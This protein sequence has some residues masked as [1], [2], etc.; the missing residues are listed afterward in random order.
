MEKL[1]REIL[2]L[3]IKRQRG[4]SERSLEVVKGD[5]ATANRSP[6][7]N[8]VIDPETISTAATHRT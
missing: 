8:D 7:R 3:E 1:M 2:M 5:T 4:R 6:A